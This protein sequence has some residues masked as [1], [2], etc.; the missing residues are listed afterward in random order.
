MTETSPVSHF[1]PFPDSLRKAGSVGLLLPN[2]QARIVL[3]VDGDVTDVG[4]G[5]P[6]ELWV[7]G[8][9]VMKA[10]IPSRPSSIFMLYSVL[11]CVLTGISK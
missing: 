1:L 11:T 4:E 3:D 6:G 10:R 7:K 9:T 5:E 8:P 2:L